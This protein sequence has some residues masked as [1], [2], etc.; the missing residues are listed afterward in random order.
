MAEAKK[1]GGSAKRFGA[2]YGRTTR[3][4]ISD[5]EKT[6]RN[7]IKCPYCSKMKI[8]RVAAGIWNCR[9]CNVKFSGAAYTLKKEEKEE[10][11]ENG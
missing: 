9:N 7:K 10:A 8:K 11:A 4:K 1:S 5:I 6:M 2:R 3:S